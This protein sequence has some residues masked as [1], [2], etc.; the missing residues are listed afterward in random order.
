M[1]DKKLEKKIQNDVAVIRRDLDT[2]MKNNASKIS[3][4]YEKL[5]GEAKETLGD[6]VD[7]VKKE[8]GQG[9]SEYDAKVQE[10]A[11]KVHGDLDDM[12]TNYPWVAI[13]VGLG[14]GL[15]L[16]GLLKP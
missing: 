7:T 1:S 9:L 6:A 2:L 4:G 15:I 14:I 16:G 3:Q 10:Y 8:V 5:K 11:N 13:T 12:V